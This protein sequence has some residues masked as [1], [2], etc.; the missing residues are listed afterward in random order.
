MRLHAY[1]LVYDYFPI[2]LLNCKLLQK[3]SQKRWRILCVKCARSVRKWKFMRITFWQ[4]EPSTSFLC[5]YAYRTIWTHN[6]LSFIL[7]A[8]ILLFLQISTDVPMDLLREYTLET[9]I[10][11]LQKTNAFLVLV[12]LLFILCTIR[13]EWCKNGIWCMS[14]NAWHRT[15]LRGFT[16]GNETT[17]AGL[18]CSR[19]L[20]TK[21]RIST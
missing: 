10:I 6:E 17:V 13:I 15:I 3:L 14:A 2:C 19:M 1:L 12:L 11:Q 4:R 8:T 9:T 7:R 5:T 21:Q 16:R 18:W 20:L